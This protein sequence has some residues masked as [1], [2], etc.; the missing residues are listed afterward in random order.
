MVGTVHRAQ[1]PVPSI[2]SRDARSLEPQDNRL[3]RPRFPSKQAQLEN[4]PPMLGSGEAGARHRSLDGSISKVSLVA[5]ARSG[6]QENQA[7]R[8]DRR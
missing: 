2:G 8:D 3:I 1:C 6:K 4:D 7:S 5:R